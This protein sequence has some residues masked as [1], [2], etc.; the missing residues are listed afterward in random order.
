MNPHNIR[1]QSQ[2]GFSL[3]ELMVAMVIGLVLLGG[4]LG[5]FLSTQQTNRLQQAMSNVQ[6]NG[7]LAVELLARDIRESGQ[8]IC[9]GDEQI[10]NL[11]DSSS[12]HYPAFFFN[13]WNPI[14]PQPAGFA[15]GLNNSHTLTL[16]RFESL[17]RFTITN[18]TTPASTDA[19]F[20]PD[21]SPSKAPRY[22]VAS[23]YQWPDQIV[24]VVDAN[25]GICLITEVSAD[26]QFRLPAADQ[27][28]VEFSQNDEV[29]IFAV[30]RS[31]YYIQNG[32]ANSIFRH[33][34]IQR[35][36]GAV[37][38]YGNNDRA[39]VEG[40]FDMRIEYG[41]DQNGDGHP[42]VFTLFDN[43]NPPQWN[44]V[45]AARLHILSYS[46]DHDNV[47]DNTAPNQ[48]QHFPATEQNP[49]HHAANN[50]G[51]VFQ[52]F[53]TTIAVRNARDEVN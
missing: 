43:A 53:T 17:G 4:V 38:N 36:T 49:S 39:I 22:E 18:D 34:Q 10:I 5:I 11:L 51:H 13:D 21:L 19:R 20:S 26:N 46:P 52:N 45:V 27:G 7:R 3:I 8:S 24:A 2:Q 12:V 48:A 50:R 16:N 15:G 37:N 14:T 35:S 9:A 40:I 33:S 44:R 23:N 32:Q 31:T 47:V 25:T 6:E 1:H 28:L 41:E 29:E 30:V 42:D